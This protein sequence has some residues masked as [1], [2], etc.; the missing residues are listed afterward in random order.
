M[1]RRFSVALAPLAVAQREKPAGAAGFSHDVVTLRDGLESGSVYG[2]DDALG[3]G[4]GC[5]HDVATTKSYFCPAIMVRPGDRGAKT[6]GLSVRFAGPAIGTP[7]QWAE[8]APLWRATAKMYISG[9]VLGAGFG[10]HTGVSDGLPLST[11]CAPADATK[12][13]RPPRPR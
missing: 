6:H 3:S 12:A 9:A 4:L 5:C 10:T 13:V 8:W 7:L 2:D 11:S 1:Q